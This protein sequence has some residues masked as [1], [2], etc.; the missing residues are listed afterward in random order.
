[1]LENCSKFF[2]NYPHQIKTPV[3]LLFLTKST[4]KTNVTLETLFEKEAQYNVSLVSVHKN[5]SKQTKQFINSIRLLEARTQLFN[6]IVFVF[7]S[8]CVVIDTDCY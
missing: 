4:I 3:S 6:S 2:K 8:V 5:C 1:M 7:N